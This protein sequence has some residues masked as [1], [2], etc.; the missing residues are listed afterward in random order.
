[1]SVSM[2]GAILFAI[3]SALI[4]ANMLICFA[5]HCLHLAT[6]LRPASDWKLKPDFT[7]ASLPFISVHVPT[8]NEPPDLVIA[9]LQALA[10]MDYPE[11][12]VLLIDNNTTDPAI[13]EP[14]RAEC[15]RLGRRFRFHHFDQVNG[16]KAGA[17]NIAMRLSDAR[18]RFVA[19]VDADYQVRPDFLKIA[20][21]HLADP[22]TAFVQF[23]QA[24][25]GVSSSSSAVEAELTDYFK[26][27]APR[28]SDD[29]SVLLTGTL[30]VIDFAALEQSGGWK[31]QTVT[32]DAELGVRLF[33]H[34]HTGR[35]VP[36]IGGRGLLPLSLESLKAQRNRWVAGNIQTLMLTFAALC[37]RRWNGATLSIFAQLTAW[38]AFWLLPGIA[39]LALAPAYAGAE[40]FRLVLE[41]AAIT[42]LG[43][44]VA[45]ALRLWINA[46]LRGE[47]FASIPAA[48]VV[49]LALVWTSSTGFLP[50]LMRHS[51]RFVRTSKRTEASESRP[52]AFQIG[53]ACAALAAAGVYGLAGAWLP[54]L[55][56]LLIGATSP[57]GWWV[58]ACLRRYAAAN[59]FSP[60]QS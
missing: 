53:I 3:A 34:G 23:P 52:L 50:A 44:G 11:Y 32:E 49:K 28:A 16:A 41:L 22:Q 14:V 1:M 27:F 12:E 19:I 20:A 45:V 58:D 15:I 57:A 10:D 46:A 47:G 8:C 21:R 25:R 59:V 13:F 37:G 6:M 5:I 2:L 24:Y 30:S 7:P 35:F 29:S 56:C 4:F 26:A 42:I 31:G 36:A 43:S 60:G 51:I 48:L 40:T 33:L 9:S 55:A 18:T 54:A 39:L 38:P 17:L